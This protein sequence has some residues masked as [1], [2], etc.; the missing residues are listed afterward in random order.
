ML[1]ST[2]IT[3][4]V[5]SL[6]RVVLPAELRFLMG[7]D[8]R[9]PLEIF[10]DVENKKIILKKYNLGCLFCGIGEGLKNINGKYVCQTCLKEIKEQVS[11]E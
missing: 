7:I 5:D 1:K 8:N 6:G 2:G 11:L 9:D 3:R 10:V 4:E